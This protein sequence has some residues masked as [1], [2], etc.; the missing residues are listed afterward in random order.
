MTDLKINVSLCMIKLLVNTVWDMSWI[1]TARHGSS[2]LA[3]RVCRQQR[4][5]QLSVASVIKPLWRASFCGREKRRQINGWLYG[6]IYFYLQSTPLKFI[7]P[8]FKI[9]KLWSRPVTFHSSP[10]VCC[11]LDLICVELE[12]G[13]NIINKTFLSQ[14]VVHSG[15][16]TKMT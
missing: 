11:G 6:I 2:I 15:K 9:E 5:L 12:N 16:I 7:A 8:Q 1:Y 13:I 14:F 4:W 10:I 3:N